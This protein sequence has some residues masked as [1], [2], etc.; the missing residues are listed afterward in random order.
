MT[1]KVFHYE[2]TNRRCRLYHKGVKSAAGPA[3]S[4]QTTGRFCSCDG[5]GQILRLCRISEE[6]GK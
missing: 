2:C 6:E 3:E 1:Y 5:R 4:R